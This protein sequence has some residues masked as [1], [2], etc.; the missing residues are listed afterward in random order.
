MPFALHERAYP[1]SAAMRAAIAGRQR[2]GALPIDRERI[3][4]QVD[5]LRFRP[6]R[7]ERRGDRRHRHRDGVDQRDAH[8]SALIPASF[9]TLA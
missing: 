9:M 8:H 1:A 7:V 4:E 6:Q 2:A 3:V 5:P